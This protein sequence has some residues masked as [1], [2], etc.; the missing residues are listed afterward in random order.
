MSH[1]QPLSPALASQRWQRYSDYRHA[2][3]MMTIPLAAPEISQAAGHLPLVFVKDANR[4]VLSALVGLQAGTNHSLGEHN[5]WLPGYTPAWLRTPPF[6]ITV[7]PGGKPTQRVLSVDT[8]SPWFTP[9]G[10][11]A[12]LDKQHQMTPAVKEVLAFLTKLEKHFVKT[13]QA[14]EA[15]VE[16]DVLVSWRLIDINGEPLPDLYR[17]DET[18]FSQLDDAAFIALRKKGALAIAYICMVSTHQLLTLQQ[19]AE[20]TSQGENDLNTLLGE[21]DDELHFDF[22]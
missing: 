18:T 13:Q 3:G 14:V 4:F 1:Y 16:H 10:E 9:E 22:D 5:N 15:L 12:L 6:R 2:Q 21:S 8:Q 19:R 7:P 20:T 11:N 17:I